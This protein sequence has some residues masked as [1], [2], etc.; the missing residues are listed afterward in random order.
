MENEEKIS[1]QE[2]TVVENS[3]KEAEKLDNSESRKAVAND[4]VDDDPKSATYVP[5]HGKFYEHDLRQDDSTK[6]DNVE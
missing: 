6:T 2:P 4:K 1:Q 3:E 5:K